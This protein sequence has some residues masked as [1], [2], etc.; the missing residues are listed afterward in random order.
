MRLGFDAAS[1][2]L[3]AIRLKFGQGG[4]ARALAI[5]R[6]KACYGT[7]AMQRE[8]SE[9]GRGGKKKKAGGSRPRCVGASKLLSEV[10]YV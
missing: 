5:I 8:D 3:R 1:I 9:D 2:G 7:I 4:V 6:F 10:L